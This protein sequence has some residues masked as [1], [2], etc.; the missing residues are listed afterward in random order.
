[1][2]PV[3]DAVIG[4]AGSEAANPPQSGFLMVGSTQPGRY[5]SR[6]D[7]PPFLERAVVIING[8]VYWEWESVQVRVAIGDPP[9]TFQLTCSEQEPWPE[10]WA[11]M[12][13]RP[14]DR[15]AVYLDGELAI[16]GFVITRQ[17][18]Y[19]AT[20]HSIQIQGWGNTGILGFATADSKTGEMKNQT[21][22]AVIK[23]LATQHGINVDVAGHLPLDKIKRFSTQ[24]GENAKEAIE[25]AARAA[26]AQVGETKDGH[27]LVVGDDAESAAPEQLIEGYNILIGQET[28]HCNMDV[29]EMNATGQSQGGDDE[30]M[31]DV[32]QR[33]R[34]AGG[35]GQFT[36]GLPTRILSE[37]PSFSI[38]QLRQ[39]MGVER[40]VN[41]ANE[42]TAII[43]VLGWQKGDRGGLWTPGD[44]V[45]VD[46]PMLILRE[47][48]MLKEA[49]FTQDN[50]SGT[51]TRLTLVNK[52]AF[53]KGEPD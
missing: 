44:Q 35:G 18:Y 15:C 3:T 46:A 1:M 14:P 13:I 25:R 24:P 16:T 9:N 34:Q 32:A 28:I 29:G 53:K 20:Q 19:D 51:R 33:G 27:L 47:N 12:R 5:F 38:N 17:V 7:V 22:L 2:S 37:L 41:Q 4:A 48:L 39:R 26:G 11:F 45:F 50:Q 8:E 31:S 6:Y 40:A 23:K 52:A 42:I 43:T 49:V 30:S 10:D 21:P 36:M